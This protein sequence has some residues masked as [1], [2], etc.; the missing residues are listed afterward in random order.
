MNFANSN[1][2][3]HGHN[4]AKM[5][6]LLNLEEANSSNSFSQLFKA[7]KNVFEKMFERSYNF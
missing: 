6:E 1:L 4:N 5:I 2:T 3:Q 7:I